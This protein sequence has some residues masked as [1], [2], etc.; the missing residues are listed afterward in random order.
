MLVFYSD[1]VNNKIILKNMRCLT[2]ERRLQRSKVNEKETRGSIANRLF[3]DGSCC[4]VRQQLV[5]EHIGQ[6]DEEERQQNLRHWGWWH[7]PA[8]G[9]QK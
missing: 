9:L 6:D 3:G 4:R 8:N 2:I 5:K 1:E 7:I